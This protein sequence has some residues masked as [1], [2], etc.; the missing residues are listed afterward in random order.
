[1]KAM[2][3][4]ITNIDQK[5]IPMNLYVKNNLTHLE[6]VELRGRGST[7]FLEAVDVQKEL[8]FSAVNSTEMISVTNSASVLVRALE[9]LLDGPSL[10][11]LDMFGFDEMT[12]LDRRLKRQVEM[13]QTLRGSD[14]H[15]INSLFADVMA[16]FEYSDEDLYSYYAYPTKTRYRNPFERNEETDLS[17]WE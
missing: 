16:R 2:D 5:S 7:A 1:M 6:K 13:R 8:W 15:V 10:E 12:Q 9:G 4:L 3:H 14:F 11:H 17:G